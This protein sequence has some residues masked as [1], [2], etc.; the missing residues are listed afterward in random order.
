LRKA[1]AAPASLAAVVAIGLRGKL[2]KA[3]LDALFDAQHQ[4]TDASLA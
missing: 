3:A 1:L 4:P 2:P